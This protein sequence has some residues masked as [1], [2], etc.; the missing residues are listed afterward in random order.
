MAA[1]GESTRRSDE[2]R[3]GGGRG[4]LDQG[5]LGG[6]RREHLKGCSWK[7]V[8][9]ETV[10]S[11]DPDLLRGPPKPHG[12]PLHSAL[13]LFNLGLS[14]LVHACCRCTALRPGSVGVIWSLHSGFAGL[15]DLQIAV[16][17]F[18]TGRE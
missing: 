10:L 16:E 11:V 4:S 5:G 6:E 18:I 17:D 14:S 15:A 13:S 9:G 3:L 7:S 8:A 2:A 1:V 12:L